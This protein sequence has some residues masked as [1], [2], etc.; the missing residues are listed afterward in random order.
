MIEKMG[1]TVTVDST[2]GVGTTFTVILILKSKTIQID[3]VENEVQNISSSSNE[4]ESD[5]NN[6]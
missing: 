5:K 1:G 6:V 2:L 4:R 3:E